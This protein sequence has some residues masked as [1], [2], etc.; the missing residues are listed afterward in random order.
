MSLTL[1][2]LAAGIGS[3]YGGPKQMEPIGP[4]GEFIIDYA[5]FDALRAGFDRLVLV[6][7]PEI[8][9]DFKAIVGRRLEQR[10]PTEYVRQELSHAPADRVKPWGTGHAVLVCRDAVREPFAVVNADDFYGRESYAALAA[11]LRKTRGEPDLY[12]MVGFVL[13]NTLSDHGSVARGVCRT[14]PGGNLTSVVERTRIER[15]GPGARFLDEAG[16][17]QPLTGDEPVSMNMWAFKPSVFG[18]LA[19]AFGAFL[20]ASGSDPKPEFFVPTVVNDLIHAGR[21]AVR[22]LPTPNRWAG[23][24]YPRDKAQVQER[25]A[26]LIRECVYP[27]PLWG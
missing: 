12:A 16:A 7:R 19:A 25:I 11:F 18:H 24:T 8:E 1:V 5:V 9:T 27:N 10:I 14:D 26:G 2:I 20:E 3:R 21:A 17:W 6:I 13:R 22:V 23:V 15:A 4:S